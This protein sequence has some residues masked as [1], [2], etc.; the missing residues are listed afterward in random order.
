MAQA[1]A[2]RSLF[3]RPLSSFPSAAM[4]VY[5]TCARP[6]CALATT[7]AAPPLLRQDHMN[8]C[9]I[10]A[11]ILLAIAAPASAAAQGFE[12]GWLSPPPDEDQSQSFNGSF[13]GFGARVGPTSVA[14]SDDGG[15][16]FDVGPRISF[17]MYLGDLRLGYRQDALDGDLTVHSL[18]TSLAVHPLYLVLL[19]NGW[20]WYSIAS[21]Y[22]DIGVGAQ[23]AT[24][25]DSTDPGFVWHWG[26]GIDIPVWT[27]DA[28]GQA[29]WINV[30]Y[31]NQRGSLDLPGASRDLSQRTLFL[32]LEWRVNTLP[33]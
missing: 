29:L 22:V 27:P 8:R 24:V 15:L 14:D 11:L 28:F 30:L 5:V 10:S 9:L 20:L 17:P 4:A 7:A 19:G 21:L 31:R 18:N 25:A 16:S 23:L 3:W 32:G 13:W 33:F 12:D 6:R 26:A 2:Q 1:Q